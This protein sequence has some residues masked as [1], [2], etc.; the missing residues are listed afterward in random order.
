MSG[1]GR[2]QRPKVVLQGEVAQQQRRRRPGGQGDPGCRGNRAV[3]PGQPAVRPAEPGVRVD[4]GEVR[5][6]NAGAGA[7]DQVLS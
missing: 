1:I 4:R 7:E 5:V 3:Y 6:A 2:Y